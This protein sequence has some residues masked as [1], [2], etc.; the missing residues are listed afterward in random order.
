MELRLQ[1]GTRSG[2]EQPPR[3]AS[4]TAR[5][6]PLEIG[7]ER[8]RLGASRAGGGR[9][10]GA[11]AR[12]LGALLLARSE[13]SVSGGERARGGDPH[14]HPRVSPGGRARR[15]RRRRSERPGRARGSPPSSSS[16]A[17]S[18]SGPSAGSAEVARAGEWI[19]DERGQAACAPSPLAARALRW[20][21]T[22]ASS[23]WVKTDAAIRRRDHACRERRLERMIFDLC[24]AKEGA[25]RAPCAATSSSA[26]R[27]R[28]G[29][30]SSRA[31]TSS[32]SVSGRRSG[33]AGSPHRRRGRA[34]FEREE[35]VPAG[36]LVQAKERRPREHPAQ[37]PLQDPVQRAEH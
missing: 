32:S 29:S 33:R 3:R 8:E 37:L 10:P 4:A 13:M 28:S 2:L 19:L 34:Q 21:S 27:A 36:G 9:C 12:S 15:A 31:R 26:A 23:G 14:A 30:P 18:A 7:H 11:R 25:S 16:A 5:S 35:R 20:Y 22:E 24:G 17:V 6:S 1:S